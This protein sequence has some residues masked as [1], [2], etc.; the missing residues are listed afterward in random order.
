[1]SWQLGV[2]GEFGSY[3][4][5]QLRYIHQI[6]NNV[7]EAAAGAAVAAARLFRRAVDTAHTEQ[8]EDKGNEAERRLYVPL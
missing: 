2:C 5:R 1:M 4:V 3:N 8:E 6:N 7:S